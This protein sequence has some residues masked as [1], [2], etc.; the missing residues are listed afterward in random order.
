M[1]ASAFAQALIA[2]TSRWGHARRFA[3][4]TAMVVGAAA[5]R[6]AFGTALE[7]GRYFLFVFAVVLCAIFLDWS[8]A[9][10]A[11]LL[12]ALIVDYVFLQ[13]HY[14]FSLD[15][16]NAV[17][18]SLFMLG[19]LAVI[20]G[21][22]S[23]R[24]LVQKLN[25]A[26]GEKDALYR[27]MR[28]RT[29][30]NLHLIG[31]TIAMEAARAGSTETREVLRGIA[32]RIAAIG[33]VDQLL[34]APGIA[35]TVDAGDHVRDLCGFISA[36]LIGR[37]PV[38]LTCDADSFAV[39]RDFAETI[40]IAINELVTNALKHAFDDGDAGH[41][42]VRLAVDPDATTLT[43]EDDG[44]GCSREATSGIGWRLVESLIAKHGG[45]MATES[46]EPG[47]R[48]RIALPRELP[49]T[50]ATARTVPG[51]AP[52]FHSPAR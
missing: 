13:P 30:N 48:I 34:S 14:S 2:R 19:C 26:H 8:S 25:R 6:L 31:A 37:R 45:T 1:E 32:A 49:S 9:L 24:L 12:S 46:A 40:G 36:S 38:T 11:S 21:G 52:P 23:V 47:C 50:A 10:W 27:E 17:T 7:G 15:T 44:R 4:A 28:H 3:A 20:I 35:G 16:G 51:V 41:I 5:L 29:A 43:V 22:Q 33:Q 39:S 42:R 18:L